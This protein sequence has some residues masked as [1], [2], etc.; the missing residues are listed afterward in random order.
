MFIQKCGAQD[1]L[2]RSFGHILKALNYKQYLALLLK[3]FPESSVLGRQSLSYHNSPPVKSK[4]I[5]I[6]RDE[7]IH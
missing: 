1:S 3:M 4:P 7:Q 2:M 5:T 6:E